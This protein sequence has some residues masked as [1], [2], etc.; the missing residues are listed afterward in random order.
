MKRVAALIFHGRRPPYYICEGC[1]EKLSK[2]GWHKTPNGSGW[3]SSGR[4]LKMFAADTKSHVVG[5]MWCPPCRLLEN[6]SLAVC[7]AR[8]TRNPTEKQVGERY[9]KLVAQRKRYRERNI[10]RMF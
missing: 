8:W 3:G 1:G 4:S 10:A 6:T 9:T 7:I 5:A 2:E